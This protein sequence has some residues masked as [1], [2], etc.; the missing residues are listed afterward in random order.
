MG[1]NDNVRAAAAAGALMLSLAASSVLKAWLLAAKLD[2]SVNNWRWS[3]A[4]A[5]APAVLVGWLALTVLP[6]WAALIFGMP[7]ILFAYAYVVWH[8]GFGPEDRVLFRRN[9][10]G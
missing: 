1:L 3:L 9:V 5:A 8:K 10:G 4:W 2:A 6:E 7:S